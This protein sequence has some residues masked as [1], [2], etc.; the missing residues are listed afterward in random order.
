MTTRLMAKLTVLA[1]LVG[2]TPQLDSG[3]KGW[4]QPNCWAAGCH[5]KAHTMKPEDKPYQCAECHDG[6]GAPPSHR[7]DSPDPCATCH[8]EKHG[9]PAAGFTDPTACNACHT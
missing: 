9:G 8:G 7:P 6:N 4:K 1:L 5:D 2:C 3:H